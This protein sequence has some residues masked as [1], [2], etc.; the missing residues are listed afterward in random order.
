MI[1]KIGYTTTDGVDVIHQTIT[2]GGSPASNVAIE[3]LRQ[4]KA[5]DETVLY[6][7]VATPKEGEDVQ[8][9]WL[10]PL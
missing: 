3:S 5:G 6:F 10:D 8:Y 4:S 1:I 2:T 9:A 7:F